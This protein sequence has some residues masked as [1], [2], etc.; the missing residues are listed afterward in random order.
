MPLP[1][2]AF[3][4]D[5]KRIKLK[6][7]C[8]L[9]RSALAIK[10]IEKFESPPPMD[11]PSMISKLELNK[12]ILSDIMALIDLKTRST[13]KDTIERSVRLDSFIQQSRNITVQR[14]AKK[15][16]NQESLTMANELFR[17]IVLM[18]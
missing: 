16:L 18:Q 15:F 9:V 2:Q 3:L 17:N 6:E 12:D 5:V 8:Y 1:I 11:I 14:P 10:W 7:Y 4:S 13:E